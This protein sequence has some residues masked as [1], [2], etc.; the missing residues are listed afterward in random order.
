MCPLNLKITY[1]KDLKG[2]IDMDENK[3]MINGKSLNEDELAGVSGGAVNAREADHSRYGVRQAINSAV[4]REQSVP[5]GVGTQPHFC[6][7]CNTTTD[8][9]V[10]SGNRMVCSVCK[11][12]PVL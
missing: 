4:T 1:I 3:E 9:Y 11:T 6:K 2:E 7:K 12:T 8:H 5:A 10:Y